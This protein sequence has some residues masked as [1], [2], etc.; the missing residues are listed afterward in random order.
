MVA[1]FW[2]KKKKKSESVCRRVEPFDHLL[3][4][5]VHAHALAL[6]HHGVQVGVLPELQLVPQSG[7]LLA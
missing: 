4:P 3:R 7:A 2:R 6:Q 1:G 5:L